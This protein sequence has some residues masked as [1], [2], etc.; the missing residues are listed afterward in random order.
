MAKS[1]KSLVI[2]IV[3]LA[4]AMTALGIAFMRSNSKKPLRI[5]P[6]IGVTKVDS[7]LVDGKYT[8]DTTY[9]KVLDFKLTDQYGQTITLDTFKNKIFVANFF[10]AQC[11]GICKRMNGLLETATKKFK[12]NSNIKFVSYTVN[13]AND[14]VPVLL[15]YAKLHDAVP[16]Q[17]YFLTG[18]KDEIYNLALKS[19]YAAVDDSAG[20][21]FVHTQNMALVDYQGNIRGIYS[22]TD[23]TEVNKMV[24]DIKLL[25]QQENEN[26]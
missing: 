11:P 16:Y 1:G 9:H 8:L 7:T 18:D 10:F 21:N 24:I 14:S 23:S 2:N 15:A 25:L 26:R 4:C 13:P 12:G 22:G 20:N 3:L 6:Y 5:L 17:W 19:Y